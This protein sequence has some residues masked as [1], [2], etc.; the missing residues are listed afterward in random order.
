MLAYHN[1]A[2]Y[3]PNKAHLL[4]VVASHVTSFS[5]FETLISAQNSY[6]VIKFVYNIGSTWKEKNSKILE[7]KTVTTYDK[8]E[9]GQWL[10]LSW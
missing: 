3:I 2:T 1:Y 9:R 10:W 7:H 6:D 5:Q 4:D 8:F